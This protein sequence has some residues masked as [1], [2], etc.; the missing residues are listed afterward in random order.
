MRILIIDNT[1][2]RDSWGSPELARFARLAPGATVHVRRAPEGDLPKGPTGFDRVILS[3][4]KTGALDDAPW[5]S[6]LHDFVRKTIDSGKPLLGVC[7]GHQTLA[8]VFEG[9][10]VLRTTREGEFGWSRVEILRDSALFDSLPREFH[11]FS[12]HFDEVTELPPG[13]LHLARSADCELQAFQLEGKPVYG[14]QFHPEKT[15]EEAEESLRKRRKLGTP[16]RF[17]HAGKGS[18]LYD[19]KVGETIFGNF[20]RA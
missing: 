10:R 15:L 7:Y 1:I 5:I 4:S 12:S 19:S 14:I 16:K 6:A 20:L 11:S 17:L 18:S 8:R 3:G 9:K 13:F 2:D